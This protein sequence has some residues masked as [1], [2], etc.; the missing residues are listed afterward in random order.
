[1]DTFTFLR[2]LTEHICLL[3]SPGTHEIHLRAHFTDE[4]MKIWQKVIRLVRERV[5]L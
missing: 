5:R 4:E 2:H 1:M 3:S